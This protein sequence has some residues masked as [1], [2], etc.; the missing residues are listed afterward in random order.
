MLFNGWKRLKDTDA[1][2]GSEDNLQYA[3]PDGTPAGHTWNAPAAFAINA[4]LQAGLENIA[5]VHYRAF[6]SGVSAPGRNAQVSL[7]VRW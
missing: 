1:A 5:D 3:T 6:A 4:H 2:P 7:R